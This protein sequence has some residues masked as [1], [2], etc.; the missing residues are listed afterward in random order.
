MATAPAA[1]LP[2]PVGWRGAVRWSVMVT[3][4]VHFVVICLLMIFA[5]CNAKARCS[6]VTVVHT[7]TFTT[8][9]AAARAFGARAAD[10][11]VIQR[12]AR[13]IIDLD[14]LITSYSTLTLCRSISKL[15]L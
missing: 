3:L 7:S 15:P 13:I 1:E 5:V 6:G 8:L 9:T 14:V 12:A 4:A 2:L 10:V 11:A